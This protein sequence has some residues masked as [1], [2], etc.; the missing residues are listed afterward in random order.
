MS[1][2]A[3]FDEN[4]IQQKPNNNIYIVSD[5]ISTDDMDIE[6]RPINETGRNVRHRS[7]SQTLVACA[8]E[9]ANITAT[10]RVKEE[11]FS[12]MASD[13]NGFVARRDSLIRHFGEF[14]L[15]KHKRAQIAHACANK[16]RECSRL[17]IEM[18]RRIGNSKFSFFE[19]LSPV[20]FDD[21]VMSAKAISGYDGEK[22][23]YQAPSLALHLGTT[24]QQVC[25]LTTHLLLKTSPEFKC[26]NL[27]ERLKQV[28]RF[29]FL[30]QSQWSN[31]VSSLALKNLVE[32]K[33]NKP[34]ILP[35]TKDV[36]KFR[37]D[38][39]ECANRSVAL[40]KKENTDAKAFKKLVDAS[41]AFTILF[42]RRRIG[43]VQYVEN[44]S[45]LRDF[46]ASNQTEFLELLT[47]SERTLTSSYKRVVAG[48]KGS[49]AIVIL[50]PPNVQEYI[51]LLLEI[52]NKTGI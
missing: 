40:L 13:E 19:M 18:R 5:N 2:K 8:S 24:L 3:I 50:F 10:L 6:I 31:K 51:N 23:T 47:E 20:L 49:R 15:K 33:W 36:I 48:G 35:L 52:R 16:M 32:R 4:A 41:L 28:K 34:V 14:C 22:K 46:S 21:V 44:E 37:S 38:I 27:E 17:L 1:T 29:R 7:A 45:Y 39:L 26:D 9:H 42:N 11:V 25:E 12:R 30:V 43:D